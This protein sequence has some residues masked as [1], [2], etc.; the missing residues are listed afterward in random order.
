MYLFSKLY[1]FL[2]FVKIAI[3][4]KLLVQIKSYKRIYIYWTPFPIKIRF[5]LQNV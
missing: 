3:M 5:V 1:K 4:E 2:I